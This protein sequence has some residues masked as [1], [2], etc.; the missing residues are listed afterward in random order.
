VTVV[1]ASESSPTR[2]ATVAIP[3]RPDGHAC[4]RAPLE[5][6]SSR[7]SNTRDVFGQCLVRVYQRIFIFALVAVVLAGM[8][9]TSASASPSRS[10]VWGKITAAYT[11]QANARHL[12]LDCTPWNAVMSMHCAVRRNGQDVGALIASFD[13]SDCT[14]RLTY[15][16][17]RTLAT[18]E[19]LSYCERRWWT[20]LP[21]WPA[22][23]PSR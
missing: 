19:E 6:F 5:T 1:L 13:R 4:R 14:V 11:A 3:S 7:D 18:R 21:V 8:A 12:T 23:W 15:T 20:R 22:P 17:T 10:I 9:A 2:P 16:A